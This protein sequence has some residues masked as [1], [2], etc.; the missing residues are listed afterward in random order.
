MKAS[1]FKFKDGRTVITLYTPW[2]E[3]VSFQKGEIVSINSY[4]WKIK[5]INRMHQGC[6]GF[7]PEKR[8]HTFMIEPV[9]HDIS[10][11]D[12]EDVELV[13]L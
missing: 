2:N 3:N 1:I 4:Q 7:A 8:I 11:Q 12:N 10:L 13:K 5:D 6:F 9:E